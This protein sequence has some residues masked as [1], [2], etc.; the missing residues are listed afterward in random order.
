VEGPVGRHDRQPVEASR[1][2]LR[3]DPQ[4]LHHVRRA[5][6]TRGTST[7]RATSTAASVS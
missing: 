3:L 1:R 4:R 7:T 2:L 6:R 5:R